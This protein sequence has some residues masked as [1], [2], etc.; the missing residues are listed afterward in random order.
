MNDI[1]IKITFESKLD[2]LPLLRKTIRSVCSCVINNEQYLQDIELAVNEALSNVICHAY[3]SK[4]GHEIQ[5]TVALYSKEVTIQIIDK[6]LTNL[7]D[8]PSLEYDVHDIETLSESG[9]GLFFI[10]QLM[11]EVTYKNEK[12][13]NILLLRKH[14]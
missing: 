2:Y 4:P 12:G 11:D 3:Q 9:R 10:H 1:S 8:P 6:G 14:I 7:K 13:E 5:V